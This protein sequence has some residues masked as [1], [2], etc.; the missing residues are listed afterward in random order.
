MASLISYKFLAKEEE[1]LKGKY[2]AYFTL[3]N[4]IF[5]TVL[6]VFYAII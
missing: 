2:F 3:A 6:V 5:L 4:V 1:K